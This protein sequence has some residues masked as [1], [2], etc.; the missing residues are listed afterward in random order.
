MRVNRSLSIFWSISLFIF[1]G[2]GTF[3]PNLRNAVL[4]GLETNVFLCKGSPALLKM[5]LIRARSLYKEG[6]SGLQSSPGLRIQWQ[7][8]VS[9]SLSFALLC[10][11]ASFLPDVR[12]LGWALLGAVII[13]LSIPEIC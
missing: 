11:A 7:E 5:L 2:E 3:D 1:T 8:E 9:L 13:I 4:F 6:R 12:G 10:V